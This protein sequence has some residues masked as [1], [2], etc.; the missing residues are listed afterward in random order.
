MKNRFRKLAALLGIAVLVTSQG[1]A[2]PVHAKEAA[3]Q[4][5]QQLQKV[6]NMR[7]DDQYVLHFYNPNAESAFQIHI[8]DSNGNKVGQQNAYD[9]RSQGDVTVDLYHTIAGLGAGTYTY[10]VTSVHTGMQANETEMSAPFSYNGASSGKLPD[11]VFS[12]SKEGVVSCDLSGM[13]GYQ[14]GTDYGISYYLYVFDAAGSRVDVIQRGTDDSSFDFG[15]YMDYVG[16]DYIYY[17]SVKMTSRD[18][19]EFLDGNESAAM[20]VDPEKTIP[21]PVSKESK[22]SDTKSCSHE[23][24]WVSER[25]ATQ[26]ANGEEIYQCKY[27]GDVKERMEMANS[28]YAK[29]NKDAI[30]AIDK[31]QVNGT[32]TLKTDMWV[33]FYASVIDT[34]KARPDVTLVV[35]YFYQGVRYTMTIPAG[36][37]LSALVDSEGY[38]GFRYLDLFFPGQEVK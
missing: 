20:P 18:I 8:Y 27:C 33:S 30:S 7:L 12:V 35:N 1:G 14:L 10:K 17:V 21:S 34:L 6:Q 29:F 11:A 32:V 2:L 22:S 5:M 31:A 36:A 16:S 26:I 15:S 37:D 25:E 4:T 28:A 38:Y 23:Y 19:N 24:E 3:A 9:F 13:S